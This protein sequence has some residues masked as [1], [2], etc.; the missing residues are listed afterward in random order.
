MFD[1]ID[2]VRL[3]VHNSYNSKGEMKPH[4]VNL[5]FVT[6]E[7]LDFCIRYPVCQCGDS[8]KIITAEPVNKLLY[9]LHC[10]FV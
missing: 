4:Q 2:Y 1:M 10:S 6:N 3:E 9:G 8:S 5:G 7:T